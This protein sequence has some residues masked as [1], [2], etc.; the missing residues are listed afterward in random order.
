MTTA[1]IDSFQAFA[2]L[3]TEHYPVKKPNM[4][5]ITTMKSRTSPAIG[6]F[7]R[8]ALALCAS[9]LLVACGHEDS[10]SQAASVAAVAAVTRNNLENTLEIASEF[11][12]YQQVDIHAKVPGYVKAIYVDIGDYV[13]EGQVL[14]VLEIPEI[15]QDLARARAG[16]HQ[17]QKQLQLAR[18][19]INRA[20][21][22]AHQ[23]E[24]TYRR[25][26]SVNEVSP[27]LVAQQEID[28]AQA[29]AA[30][31]AAEL[32]SRQA[33]AAAA[34]DALA[35]A[36]AN[37]ERVNTMVDYAKIKA[38][39]TGVITK[40][41]ADTGSMIP[42]S[43]QSSQQIP[44][45]MLT[46]VDPLRLVFPVPESLVPLVKIDT[47]LEVTVPAL[48]ETLHAKIWRFTGKAEDAT[49][50][51]ETQFLIPNSQFQFKPGMLASVRFILA[52][53]EQVL[54]IP[55][56]AV[57]SAGGSPSVLVVAPDNRVEERKI[58]LGIK[59]STQ[60]EVISGLADNEQVI[61]AR[62]AQFKPGQTVQPRV[63]SF[64]G[65]SPTQEE[66]K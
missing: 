3:F 55:V 14:A 50:T 32:S 5:L 18:S 54:T 30:A 19:N 44:I 65:A 66:A 12:P 13:K 47:P 62:R 46:Q 56:E 37:E 31:T 11:E 4:M 24:I 25:M 49:R 39:F 27:N 45:V 53:R 28:V 60:Y 26:A 22:I 48:H 17:A 57:D 20:A 9:L 64:D 40:R 42:Q 10:T 58:T 35:E 8:G 63:V 61:I 51:M 52:R 38:P 43:I 1:K 7:S 16:K 41:Y 21:A 36:A 29:Q 59:S 2:K 15:E 33:A 34:L 23:A 6:M